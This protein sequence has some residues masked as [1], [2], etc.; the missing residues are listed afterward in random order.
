[1]TNTTTTYWEADGQSL[2]TLAQNIETLGGNR[3]SPPPFRGE[4]D[5]IPGR[6]GQRWQQKTPDSRTLELSMWVRGANPDG[7]IPSGGT[8]QHDLYNDNWHALRDL[9]WQPERQFLLRKRFKVAG[10]V[11]SAVALAEF[12]GGLE[13]TMLGRRASR[14]TV[15]LK[16]A[17]P[18]F[19]DDELISNALVNGD[20][21]VSVLG[22]ASTNN[23][24]ITINGS[25][26]NTVI[27]NKTNNIQVEYH[28]ALGAGAKAVLDI[29]NFLS[30]TT[31]SGVPAYNSEADVRHA[32]ASQWLS[33]KKGNNTVNVVS[34][35]GT[36]IITLQHRA[37][38]L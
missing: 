2:Q 1:M 25:R 11:R 21:T 18:Y 5:V 12:S 16:L 8:A 17:D 23:I 20:Q 19:Y 33:L 34:S 32:G 22:D 30:T 27:L 38:W 15:D 13:P 10:A 9:L 26:T 14:F 37:A 3:E 7:S 28:A 4:D 31:P 24:L 29:Q 6:I 36:G 35:T